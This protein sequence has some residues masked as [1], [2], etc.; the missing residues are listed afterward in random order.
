M[1]FFSIPVHLDDKIISPYP[2]KIT[3]RDTQGHIKEMYGVEVFQTTIS[4]IT[5]TTGI[6]L[7]TITK[8]GSNCFASEFNFTILQKTHP[9]P[10][11]EKM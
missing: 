1:S 7:L 8:I 9:E 3:T 2:R 11:K 5:S 4:G 6:F 10:D